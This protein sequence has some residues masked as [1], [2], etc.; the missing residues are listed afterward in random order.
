M[1]IMAEIKKEEKPTKDLTFNELRKLGRS[2]NIAMSI[3][4]VG[5]NRNTLM[6][7]I[8]LLGYEIDANNKQLVGK[9]G[10]K[11][12]TRRPRVVKIELSALIVH[13]LNNLISIEPCEEFFICNLIDLKLYLNTH[14]PNK[15]LSVKEKKDIIQICKKIKNYCKKGIHFNNHYCD[16]EDVYKDANYIKH[17]GDI[18]SVRKCLRD[19]N[20]L[21]YNQKSQK[22]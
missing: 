14:N 18:P 21:H 22:L 4:L 6:N 11:D 13:C 5:V 8:K 10:V 17:Y 12:K 7:E 20:H 16:I 1:Y 19:L 2:Y 15:M 3:D 9:R